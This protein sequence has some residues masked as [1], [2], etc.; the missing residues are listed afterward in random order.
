MNGPATPAEIVEGFFADVNAGDL[1]AAF[2][3]MSPD[4]EFWIAGREWS[5][6]GSYD[7]AGAMGVVGAKI[8]P[9]LAGP[10]QI[11]PVG[12][13]AQG[14]R[15]AVEA[16]GTAPTRSGVLYENQYHFLFV[17]RDGVIVTVKEY[18]D[19]LHASRVVCP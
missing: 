16:E 5:V 13:T 9:A 10:L 2:G 4:A 15:V 12:V 6:G 14:E 17:V 3:R 1:Q 19:T 7:P 11:T 8:A 18:Q